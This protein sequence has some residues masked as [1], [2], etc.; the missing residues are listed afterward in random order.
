L[1]SSAFATGVG[2]IDLQMPRNRKGVTQKKKE[3]IEA[4]A[5]SQNAS[6]FEIVAHGVLLLTVGKK[7]DRNF[8][9]RYVYDAVYGR[10][11]RG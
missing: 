8:K 11:I 3:I 7:C 4:Y 9:K 10:G 2:S 5:L 6:C 1:P